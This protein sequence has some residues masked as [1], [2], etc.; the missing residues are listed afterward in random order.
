MNWKALESNPDV[1]N[2]LAKKYGFASNEVEFNE[3]YSLEDWAT[4]LIRGPVLGVI[5]LFP[6]CDKFEE[7]T[8]GC[9][10]EENGPFFIKQYADN[11]CGTIAIFNLM[12]NLKTQHKCWIQENSILHDFIKDSREESA[13]ER[14]LRLLNNSL[15][16]SIHRE[17]VQK[18][19]TDVKDEVAY[20]FV[21]FVEHENHLYELDGR[22]KHPISHGI[23]SEESFLLDTS[24]VMQ[25][26]FDKNKDNQGFS[27]LVLSGIN[28]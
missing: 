4:A 10:K 13:E 20:H 21:A 2:N 27:I 26:Y 24:K 19:E 28:D 14:G 5:F 9:S 25:S 17:M 7:E 11:S 6:V 15:I 8:E 18:G 16:K 3:L 23:T 12:S 22:K 1:F